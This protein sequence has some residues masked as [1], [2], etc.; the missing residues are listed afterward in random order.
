MSEPLFDGA[1][2]EHR[3]SRWRKTLFRR[4]EDCVDVIGWRVAEG[5]SGA[6]RQ[7]LRDALSEREGRRMPTEWQWA[8]A[9]LSPEEMR[10]EVA[11]AL[12]EP[13]GYG[14][15]P[16]RPLTAEERLARLEYRVATQ[17]GEQGRRLVEENRR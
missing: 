17:L 7:D 11:R 8:I 3:I 12:V 10:A 13:L 4:L 9:I 2:F 14:V 5:A 1:D 6:R 15:A 16:I